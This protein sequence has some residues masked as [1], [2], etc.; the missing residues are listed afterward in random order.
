MYR[1]KLICPACSTEIDKLERFGLCPNEDCKAPLKY[2]EREDESGK[3][4][5]E[6]AF[7]KARETVT[8]ETEVFEVV[9]NRE[10]VKIEKSNLGNHIVTYHRQMVFNWI[11]CPGC[12]S[13]MFQNNIL[14]GSLEHKC[15]KCK[16]VTTYIFAN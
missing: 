6:L 14:K 8:D 5:K 10:N 13:K 1:N 11:Y 4:I 9:Y 16:A 3:L 12:E 2:V 15:H 7:R